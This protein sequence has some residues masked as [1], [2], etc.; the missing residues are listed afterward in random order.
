MLNSG[1]KTLVKKSHFILLLKKLSY[2]KG[3][4]NNMPWG[5]EI[6]PWIQSFN[7]MSTQHRTSEMAGLAAGNSHLILYPPLF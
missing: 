5:E 2:K 1:V 3:I 6:K 4:G 7:H